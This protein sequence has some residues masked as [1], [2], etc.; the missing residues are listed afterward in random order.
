MLPERCCVTQTKLKKIGLTL[1]QQLM[2]KN[3]IMSSS[4]WMNK[5]MSYGQVACRP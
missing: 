3:R 1:P 4:S 5:L 2:S